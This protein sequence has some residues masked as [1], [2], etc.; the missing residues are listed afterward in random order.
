MKKYIIALVAYILTVTLGADLIKSILKQ[1][2]N[3]SYAIAAFTNFISY[4][5]LLI[6]LLIILK[7]DLK[8]D[9]T[10]YK[11][12]DKKGRN[13][14][15]GYLLII[16]GNLISASILSLLGKSNVTSQNQE[17][18]NQLLNSKFMVIMIISLL[19]IPI[20]EELIF[21]KAFFSL[22]NKFNFNKYLILISSSI[23]FGLIH[24]IFNLS[25]GL[26][27][28]ILSIPYITSGLVLGYIYISNDEN[29]YTVT[30]V[31]ILNNLI[32]TI[33]ILQA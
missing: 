24:V 20:I 30:L 12:Q 19:F 13:I 5:L 22:L 10:I 25:N 11:N 33:L 18:I 16:F 23:L 28:L 27:E 9:F 2:T 14:G 32:A 4:I 3:D 31:H 15:A 7:K 1:L 26:D 21:R 8:T 29:I 17:G 6:L